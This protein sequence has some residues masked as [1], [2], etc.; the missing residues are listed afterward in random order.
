MLTVSTFT[1]M[2]GLPAKKMP[3]RG[4]TLGRHLERLSN[5]EIT[6]PISKVKQPDQHL[7]A[8]GSPTPPL[9]LRFQW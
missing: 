3:A 8:F 9:E 5:A 2:F 7:R 4:T 6:Q 1:T